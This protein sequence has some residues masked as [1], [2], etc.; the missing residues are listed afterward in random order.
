MSTQCPRDFK[1]EEDCCQQPDLTTER[2]LTTTLN[3]TGTLTSSGV[4]NSTGTLTATGALN[5]TGTLT[6]SNLIIESHLLT[7]QA[8][9][10]V[11]THANQ[12]GNGITSAVA[13]PTS[14]DMAGRIN[15]VGTAAADATITLTYNTPYPANANVGPIVSLWPLNGAGVIGVTGGIPVTSSTNNAF[16]FTFQDVSGA[17]PAYSYSVIVPV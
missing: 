1:V 9:V 8:T 17:N 12:S 5:A 11:V 7:K 16:T 10:P 2:I 4:L 6:S 15:I 3:T 14:T 13:A